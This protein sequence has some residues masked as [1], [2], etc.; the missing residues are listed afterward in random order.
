MPLP[1]PKLPARHP[2]WT[3]L[4]ADLVTGALIEEIPLGGVRYSRGLNAAGTL[5]GSFAYTPKTAALLRP[6]TTPARTALYALRDGQVMWG[7]IIWT[8][9]VD[10]DSKVVDLGCADWWSYYDHR[11][12][13]TTLDFTDT[14][15]NDIVRAILTAMNT[16]APVG[17]DLGITASAG[18]SGRTLDRTFDWFSYTRVADVLRQTA[19]DEGGPDIRF[20]TVGSI[21]AGV[22]R[23][24]AIGTPLLGRDAATTGI[25]I[26]YGNQGA[27]LESLVEDEDGSTVE[28]THYALGP[29]SEEAKL[30][31]YATQA[32]LTATYGW[33]VLEGTTSYSDDTLD[34]DE[35]INAKA[36]ADLASRVGVRTLPSGSSRG[37]EVGTID[38]GDSVLL[39]VT[40]AWYNDDPSRDDLRGRWSQTTRVTSFVVDIPDNGGVET[41]TPTFGDLV[42]A[43]RTI[44]PA[45]APP[46]R[47]LSIA[48]SAPAGGD[49]DYGAGPYGDGPYGE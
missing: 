32:S 26:D 1:I 18:L 25:V 3:Y 20:D 24:L 12:I 34:S 4:A 49:E 15:Q 31:G 7:G 19:E 41:V 43:S 38:P 45:A 23:Q 11:L 28:S 42:V 33:P 27:A 29:G 8:R 35:A 46:A 39:E 37:I 48:S 13:T 9:R 6:A 5:T 44:V 22:H 10:H 16:A 17:A 36:R 40:S 14:D 47:V 30:V 21:A 2:R